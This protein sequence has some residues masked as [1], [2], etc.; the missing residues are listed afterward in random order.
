M[1]KRLFFSVIGII[2]SLFVA[3]QEADLHNLWPAMWITVPDIDPQGYGVYEFKKEVSLEQ[4]PKQAIVHVTGD[5]RYK[6]FVNG[7]LVSLGPA[8]SDMHHWN[9]ETV[10]IAPQL[11]QGNNE[12]RAI[13]WNEGAQRAEANMSAQTA[14]LL[15]GDGEMKVLTTNDSWLCA[16]NKAYSPKGS[17][18]SKLTYVVTGPGERVDMNQTTMEWEKAHILTMYSMPKDAVANLVAGSCTPWLLQPSLLQQRELKEEHTLGF[19]RLTVP[20]HT[21]KTILLDNKVLTNAYLNMQFSKG[22]DSHITLAYQE[23]L[24]SEYPHK[25]NR[26]ETDGK[27]MIGREDEVISNGQDRQSYT[28]LT[29]RTYRYVELTIETANEPLTIDDVYGTATGYPFEMR[30]KLNYDGDLQDFL[31]IG[32]RTAKLCTWETY[33]DCPYYEQLQYLGDS[34]IQMLVTLYNVG[35][36]AFIRNYLNLANES[37]NVEGVTQS[38]YPARTPQYIQPYALHYIWSLHDYMMYAQQRDFI[39]N[40]LMSERSILDYFHHFQMEDGRLKNLPGWN[41]TDWV[42][43]EKSWVG[44][45]CLPLEDGAT[46]VMDLQLLY[47]YQMAAELERELGLKELA[48]IYDQRATQLGKAIEAAYWDETRGLYADHFMKD[49]YSQHANALAIITGLAKG[50]R[51]KKIAQALESDKTLAPASIY[52]KYY[53]HQAMIQAGLGNHYLSWLDKWRENIRMGLTTWG[54]TSNVDETRSDCHAWGASPNIEIFRTILGID[55]DAPGFTK[56]RI[57]PHLGD[58]EKIGGEMPHPN[59]TIKVDYQRKKTQLTAVIIL[60][61]GTTGTFIWAGREYALTTGIN[62]IVTK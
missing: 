38:R 1:M 31:T 13:V 62:N 39:A 5:N 35:D 49:T 15:Y 46:S 37:R 3:A 24:Y 8:R 54:E 25:G 50:E 30:A 21:K 34:R 6:F 20:A 19:K 58:I 53:V 51:A 42:D 44:G 28:T 4:V 40:K 52:F 48:A 18:L 36:D 32:W 2:C 55:S 12:V 9:Y 26:N 14:F 57:A 11:R 47:A 59:G 27:K 16:Q 7:Q 10:D 43:G 23:A 56:V 33:T 22:K 45:V 60:P 61:E 17:E 41:F 29:F